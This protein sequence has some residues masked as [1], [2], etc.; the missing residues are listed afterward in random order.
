MI[1][2][3][4]YIVG[5]LLTYFVC[6]CYLSFTRYKLYIKDYTLLFWIALGFPV[7][8]PIAFICELPDMTYKFANFIFK[9]MKM[10][11]KKHDDR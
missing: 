3:I 6:L 9:K 1:Y 4:G 7:A 11:R 10:W 2:L 8:F 5:A